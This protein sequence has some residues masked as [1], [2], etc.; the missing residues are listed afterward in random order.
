MPYNAKNAP[1]WMHTMARGEMEECNQAI[2][3]FV[4]TVNPEQINK[5]IDDIPE[6]YGCLQVMPQLQKD[7]YKELLRIRCSK[8]KEFGRLVSQ[9]GCL[10]FNRNAR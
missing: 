10:M 5:T 7:F 4:N 6:A 3:R 9:E 2:N 1:L 8:I